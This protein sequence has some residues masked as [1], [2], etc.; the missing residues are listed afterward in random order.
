M[1]ERLEVGL[2]QLLVTVNTATAPACRFVLP[3]LTGVTGVTAPLVAGVTVVD[4]PPLPVVPV[5]PAV[6]EPVVPDVAVPTP[7]VPDA[8]PGLC[9]VDPALEPVD[10]VPLVAA[11][12]VLPVLDA[13]PEFAA[14][15]P[16]I[17]VED[18]DPSAGLRVPVMPA[19][20]VAGVFK[21]G[22]LSGS[23]VIE[24]GSALDP[25]EAALAWRRASA[26]LAAGPLGAVA[27]LAGPAVL[28]APAEGTLGD[29]AVAGETPPSAVA[30]S[31]ATGRAG[32]GRAGA[33]RWWVVRC[34]IG[35]AMCCSSIAPP[36]VTT[37]AAMIV[38]T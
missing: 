35:G 29:D 3:T 26:A 37:A 34:V 5:D 36:A 16:L 17:V 27:A 31:A 20:L 33:A 6:E 9:V 7:L 14:G 28:V 22:M 8:V 18:D 12:V 25:V 15:V 19:A 2:G 32:A 4:S 10:A 38:T 1:V 11:L 30:V 23:A 13:V 21:N 24:I